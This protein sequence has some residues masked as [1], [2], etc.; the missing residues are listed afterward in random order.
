MQR[1]SSAPRRITDPGVIERSVVLVVLDQDHP[2]RWS[3]A[4]IER[5][6]FDVEPQAVGEAVERLKDGN[7]VELSGEEV[8]ALP[9][10]R[11]LNGLG[12]ICA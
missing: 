7:V 1:K 4:E 3:R 6:L 8:W 10:T 5:E 12:M 11:H 9:G 2:P